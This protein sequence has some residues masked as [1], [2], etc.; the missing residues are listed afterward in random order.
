MARHADPMKNRQYRIDHGLC[1]V[2]G[3]EA[4]PYYL[5]HK[6]RQIGMVGRMLKLMAQ[7]G[8]VEQSKENGRNYY[9]VA[10]GHERRVDEFSW[11]PRGSELDPN[12][13][14]FRP[15]LGRRPVDLDETL[16]QIFLDAGRPLQIEEVV[17][18]WGRLR[19]KR[20]TESLAGDMR[21]LIEAQR[22]RDMRN[23]KRAAIVARQ[24]VGVPNAAQ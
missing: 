10:P 8:V 15:R 16:V 9:R 1:P 24:R 12:D 5:C 11:R 7:R 23:A 22:L 20:K 2:C 19:S 18:A 4:A 17:A 14:R 6:H 3:D 13:K 21:A